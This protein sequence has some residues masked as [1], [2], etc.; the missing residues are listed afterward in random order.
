MKLSRNIFVLCAIAFLQGMVFYAPVATLYRQA[1]G[2]SLSGITIIESISLI[3]ALALEMP[4]GF[5]AE[6]LGYRRMMVL[7]SI[8]FAVSKLIFW[9]A[10]GFGAFLAERVLLAVV[11][12]GI[13][14]VDTTLLYLS[15][16]AQESQRAF[17]L[18]N[19]CSEAGL[20]LAAMVQ[21]TVF[22]SAYRTAALFTFG[23][24]AAAAVL[25]LWLTPVKA[26]A[27]RQPQAR[28]AKALRHL[29]A[30]RVLLFAA[31]TALFSEAAHLCTTFLSQ[32]L[33]AACGLSDGAMG[34][35]Y[36]AVTLCGLAGVFS[37]RLTRL[38]GAKKLGGALCVAG[39]VV[40]LALCLLRTAAPALLCLCLLQLCSA[41]FAP[42]R[43]QLQNEA[44][45][46]E[47]RAAALSVQ[48]AAADLA[49]VAVNLSVGRAADT[50]LATAF[51]L[52]GIATGAAWVCFFLFFPKNAPAQ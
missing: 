33:Y 29:L 6:K 52:C 38:C 24:Y 16:T 40:C 14:G 2:V 25:S 20:L 32:P 1:A 43:T 46:T 49:A 10:E 12:A 36:L 22:R 19:A 18:Y 4:M 21:A 15:C 47:L 27:Q 8:L 34:W 37:A 26:P 44:V 23:A 11:I 41:L 39:G 45:Q 9:R 28:A 17:G 42:L 50:S 35:C 30:P 3:L 31:G 5:L 51:V 13:S 48:A 7:C